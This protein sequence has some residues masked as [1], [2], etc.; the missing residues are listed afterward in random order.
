MGLLSFF[1]SFSIF[2]FLEDIS[3]FS[4]FSGFNFDFKDKRGYPFNRDA[5]DVNFSWGQIFG[6]TV[7]ELAE[8]VEEFD[9]QADELSL[10]I[11]TPIDKKKY[12]LACNKYKLAKRCQ[13]Y[14]KDI[15]EAKVFKK[16][17]EI[18]K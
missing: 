5:Q 18:L 7:Y 3:T 8:K 17:D 6:K 13:R 10:K 1:V 4:E 11:N 16:L 12:A 9:K 14:R 15:L 2:S